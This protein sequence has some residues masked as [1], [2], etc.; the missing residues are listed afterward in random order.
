[1]K[2]AL[3]SIAV[4]LFVGLHPVIADDASLLQKLKQDPTGNP[5]AA[6][7]FASLPLE[8]KREYAARM[9]PIVLE[10]GKGTKDESFVVAFGATQSPYPW[11]LM[12]GRDRLELRGGNSFTTF[13]VTING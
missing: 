13:T 3:T 6:S 4:T 1:M 2:H 11:A 5:T 9:G 8:K 7:W 12:V 10:G